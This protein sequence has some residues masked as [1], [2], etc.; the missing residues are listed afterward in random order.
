LSSAAISVTDK[1]PGAAPLGTNSLT[2]PVTITLCPTATV[3]AALVKTNTP[4][5]VAALP[6]PFGSW[7]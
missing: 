4:S 6:S 5:E 1:K 7:M 2:V 3:G